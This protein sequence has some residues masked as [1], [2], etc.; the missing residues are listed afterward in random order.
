MATRMVFSCGDSAADLKT[1][2]PT[3]EVVGTTITFDT[4]QT[5]NIGVGD[6]ITY[7]TSDICFIVG[8]TST[9]VWTVRS[10]T[11]GTPTAATAGTTVNEIKHAFVSCNDALANFTDASHLNSTDLTGTDIQLDIAC[12][13]DAADDTTTVTKTTVAITTDATRYVRVYTPYDTTGECNNDQRHDG[14]WN[15]GK[16]LQTS[17]SPDNWLVTQ[18]GHFRVEGLQI[19][20]TGTGNNVILMRPCKNGVGEV[21]VESVMVSMASHGGT[22][23]NWTGISLNTGSQTCLLSNCTVW[24]TGTP[25]TGSSGISVIN[26]A[27]IARISHC[28]VSGIETGFFQSA[29][30]VH[31]KNCL[32]DC[33]TAGFSGTFDASSTDNAS[34]QADAPGANPRNSQTFTFVDATT[35]DLHLD[36]AD[37]G[38]HGFGADLSADTYP[39]TVDAD[40]ETRASPFDIGADYNSTG[41][42]GGDVFIEGFQWLERGI[43]SVTAARFGGVMEY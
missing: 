17:T 7:N 26:S 6:Q 19:Q 14:K 24:D 37:T 41:A 36:D 5:G 38:A 22:P 18:I 1:G 40:R 10:A 31:V 21:R 23:L 8:K 13:R 9:T 39:V 20:R 43:G 2:S 11:G 25:L 15:T 32:A 28:T 4:A 33:G 42:G 27:R 30:T 29:G 16:Y 12:Y 34:A 35:G 3:C